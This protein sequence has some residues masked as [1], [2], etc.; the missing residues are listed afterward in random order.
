MSKA[1]EK[2]VGL[3]RR[4]LDEPEG[5]LSDA[6]MRHEIA[7]VGMDEQC[8]AYTLRRI[9]QAR[10]GGKA[11]GPESSIVKLFGSDLKQKWWELG[12][13]IAGAQASGW[14]GPGFEEEDLTMTRE[15][16]RSRGN[17]IEGGT[18]EIQLNIVAKRV[19][20]LP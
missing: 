9:Q 1:E 18:S 2:L 6:F 20:G 5:P 16:L 12:T 11:P 4:H 3:A 14:E 19:L 7:Q 8:F 17:T 13:R 10:E 15:W